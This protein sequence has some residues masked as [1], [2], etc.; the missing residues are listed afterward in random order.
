M[1][2]SCLRAH[3]VPLF[4]LARAGLLGTAGRL[5]GTTDV[6]VVV[7]VAAGEVVEAT[8]GFGERRQVEGEPCGATQAS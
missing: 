8:G 5:D 3:A 7:V 2:A 4:D 6:D 1:S